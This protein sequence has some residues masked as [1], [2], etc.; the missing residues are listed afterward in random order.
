LAVPLG[1]AL[2]E[3]KLTSATRSETSK[4]VVAVTAAQPVD[5]AGGFAAVST[6][7]RKTSGRA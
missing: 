2:T 3:P 4:R 1:S 7:S 6:S 5:A